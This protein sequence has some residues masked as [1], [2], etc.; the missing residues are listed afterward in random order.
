[1]DSFAHF[2]EMW[3]CENMLLNGFLNWSLKMLVVTCCYQTSIL[4]L[5]TG[6]SVGML[7]WQRKERSVKKQPG[8]T[9]I[10]VNNEV[11]TFVVHDQDHPQMIEVCAEPQRLSWGSC[12]M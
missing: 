6:I 8:C 12:I 11:H 1:M 3:S 7:N 9:W 4:L 2:I 5:V 10:E